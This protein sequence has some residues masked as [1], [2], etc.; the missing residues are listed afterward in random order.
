MK[1]GKFFRITIV[2]IF[3]LAFLSASAQDIRKVCGEAIYYAPE[4]VTMEQAKQIAL[5]RA[6]TD[7]LAVAYGTIVSQNNVTTTKNEQGKSEI[8]LYSL[9]GSEVKGEWLETIGEPEYQISYEKGMLVVKVSVCGK[10]REIISAGVDFMAKTLRN[11]TDERFESDQFKDGDELFLLFRSPSDGYLAVYLVDDKGMAYCLLP[12]RAVSDG[13]VRV[14]ANKNYLFFSQENI[15]R[16]CSSS[17][18]DEYTLTCEK[19]TENNFLYMIFSPNTFVKANDY[20]GRC[21]TGDML[22]PRELPFKEFQKWVMKNRTFDKEMRVEI[23][24]LTIIK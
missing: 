17:M 10:A 13:N 11:G 18:V 9:G 23:K 21:N 2:L 15:D 1:N 22:L 12:Y 19:H 14:E 6:K 8:N 24:N 3:C 5:Q 4:N 7:A 20:L 16:G